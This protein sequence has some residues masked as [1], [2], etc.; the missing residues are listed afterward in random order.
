MKKSE[1]IPS[2]V[3]EI[4]I[5]SISDGVFTVDHN[6]K[7]MFFNN[8]AEIITGIPRE[9]AVG[10]YCWEVFRANMCEGDCALKR[11][12]KEGK[13]FVSTST[14]IIDSNKKKIPIT[15][16]TS[17][18]KNE[19]GEI[20]GGVEIFRDTS[21]V[22]ELRKELDSRF[23][24]GDMV[25]CSKAM[26]EIYDILP[27]VAESDS[28]VLIQG[29]TGTGKELL[30]RAIHNSSTRKN[31]KFV[32]I[33]CSAL[34][35]NLLESELFG[36]KAG[37]FTNAVKDKSGLFEE[38]RG[39]TILLDEIGDISPAFQA[40]LL[41]VLEE[42]EF[43]P[44]GSVK[45]IKSDVRIIAAT[46]KNIQGMVETG[47]FRR[48]LFYRINVV[49]FTLPPLNNRLE[50]IPLLVEHFIKRMNKIRGRSVLGIDHEVLEILMK[51]NFPG[52]I[53]ELEN[54]IEH[55]F[56]LC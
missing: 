23:Q 43:Q 22:E 21:L 24:I 28:T 48:D 55:A 8:A 54:I 15:T 35:D 44:L 14:Y 3:T 16:S 10:R 20:L 49:Q 46:N 26:R 32:A 5:E 37:A 42:H 25:S 9:E 50:D 51:H 1:T 17:T 4:I 6:W 27:Q 12:M 30:S 38:A 56:I 19:K 2:N 31:K 33:N 41:R 39:G 7:I 11:T 18:L 45:T 47:E 13:P 29:E 34:P 36:Y 52:N 40:R 53:R